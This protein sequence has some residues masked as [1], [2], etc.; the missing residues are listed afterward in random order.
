MDSQDIILRREVYRDDLYCLLGW[1]NDDQVTKHLNEQQSL[2]RDIEQA[3]NGSSNEI[4]THR[5]NHN[6]RFFLV[7]EEE[8]E[9]PIG[10]MRLVNKA[11]EG[12]IVLAIGEKD[13][14]GQGLG[15]QTLWEGLKVAFFNMRLDGLYAKINKQNKRSLKLFKRMGFKNI[16]D[17]DQE[18]VYYLSQE[19]FLE[20]AVA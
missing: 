8:E 17:T 11:E 18:K 13:K 9:Q 1:V 10:Y 16:K 2:G 7:E 15:K 4:F 19:K 5:F 12:E 3:I 14:W 6:G 20:L